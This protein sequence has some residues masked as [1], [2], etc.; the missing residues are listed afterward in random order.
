MSSSVLRSQAVR[1]LAAS[2]RASPFA[3]ARAVHPISRRYATT[4]DP[5]H[6]TDAPKPSDVPTPQGGNNALMWLAG[7][8]ALGVGGWYYLREDGQDIHAKRKA[9]QEAAVA[10]AKELNEL[11]KRTAHDVVREGEKGYADLK[12]SGKDK[13]DDVRS[14]A[15]DTQSAVERQYDAAKSSVSNTYNAAAHTVGDAEARAKA[16]Y[17]DAKQRAEQTTQSWGAWFGSWFGLGRQKAEDAERK[18]A[19]EVASG[20]S[21]VQKEAEKRA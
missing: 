1:A 19:L 10:K 7:A 13:L 14:R 5:T 18:T 8:T 15:N 3:A 9:D 16:T 11:G 12:A 20:A 21:K 6:P 2:S 4:P 17:D